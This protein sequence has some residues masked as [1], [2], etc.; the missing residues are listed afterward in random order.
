MKSSIGYS[1]RVFADSA[2][3]TSLVVDM[4]RDLRGVK[5]DTMIGSGLSGSL[6][7]PILARRLRKRWAI[8]RKPG[9]ATHSSS[10]FQGEI[11]DRWIFVDDFVASGATRRRVEKAVN[12]LFDNDGEPYPTF[13]GTYEYMWQMNPNMTM[14]TPSRNSF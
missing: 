12:T 3:L 4:R 6:I 7:I 10:T 2:S 13:V 1:S 8:I 11:G 5:F 14:F 9:E